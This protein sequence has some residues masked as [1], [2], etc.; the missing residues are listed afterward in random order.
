MSILQKLLITTA[1]AALITLGTVAEA[2]QTSYSITDL[3]TFVPTDIN[4]KG[5]IVGV[6]GD[7][8][9]LLYSDGRF[10]E[11]SKLR[12]DDN[13]ISANAINDKGQVVGE[14]TNIGVSSRIFLHSDGI[15]QDLGIEGVAL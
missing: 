10:T 4:K 9:A 14:S 7:G 13:V 11:I 12:S 15:T 1:G 8:R 6:S 3:G 2:R 5:Q